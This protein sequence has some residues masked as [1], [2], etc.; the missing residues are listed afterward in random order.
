M[1]YSVATALGLLAF[2]FPLS[3][4]YDDDV[5]QAICSKQKA[6]ALCRHQLQS[7]PCSSYV[8]YEQSPVRASPATAPDHL[9][10]RRAT[11]PRSR[12]RDSGKT[13]IRTSH[14]EASQ[15]GVREA[16][17]AADSRKQSFHDAR[18]SSIIDAAGGSMNACQRSRRCRAIWKAEIPPSDGDIEVGRVFGIGSDKQSVP[19]STSS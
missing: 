3:H 13:P 9:L 7:R 14:T 8:R 2:F 1:C 5:Q 10:R 4:R 6:E 18:R 17:V 15:S 11:R 16:A 12:R 19:L